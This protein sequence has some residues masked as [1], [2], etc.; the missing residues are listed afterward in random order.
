MKAAKYEQDPY[1]FG[2]QQMDMILAPIA[3]ATIRGE[4]TLPEGLRRV[5]HEVIK[6]STEYMREAEEHL[7]AVKSGHNERRVVSAIESEIKQYKRQIKKYE[8][9]I[10]E[11][12]AMEAPK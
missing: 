8:Q 5:Y 2:R 11:T 9:K 12:Y 10:Q 7:A 4:M 6:A 3:E 1:A